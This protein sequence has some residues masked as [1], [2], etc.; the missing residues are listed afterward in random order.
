MMTKLT[1]E[2]A[3]PKLN[4][5]KTKSSA[6]SHTGLGSRSE[7]KLD[8]MGNL[9]EQ[10]K[11]LDWGL[12]ERMPSQ[13]GSEHSKERLLSGF[14]NPNDDATRLDKERG[15]QD[16][17][18]IAGWMSLGSINGVVK[19]QNDPAQ[20]KS[21]TRALTSRERARALGKSKEQNKPSF[22]PRRITQSLC[23]DSGFEDLWHR[24]A[25]HRSSG[26]SPEQYAA[27]RRDFASR[28]T[29]DSHSHGGHSHAGIRQW[30]YKAPAVVPVKNEAAVSKQ[31]AQEILAGVLYQDSLRDSRALLDGEAEGQ[32]IAGQRLGQKPHRVGAGSVR[33][34]SR[35]K[36][37]KSSEDLHDFLRIQVSPKPKSPEGK[38]N[39]NLSNVPEHG[40]RAQGEIVSYEDDVKRAQNALASQ[41]NAMILGSPETADVHVQQRRASQQGAELKFDHR[42]STNFGRVEDATGK[43]VRV[44]KAAQSHGASDHHDLELRASAFN[45]RLKR[46]LKMPSSSPGTSIL[47]DAAIK[48]RAHFMLT[49]VGETDAAELRHCDRVS[50]TLL[51]RGSWAQLEHLALN[52]EESL[53]VQKFQGMEYLFRRRPRTSSPDNT[54]S[55]KPDATLRQW[56]L[57]AEKSSR[58]GMSLSN[59]DVRSLHFLPTGVLRQL[60]AIKSQLFAPL[61]KQ[62][63]QTAFSD[64]RCALLTCKIAS[65]EYVKG[66]V[67]R[68]PANP[69]ANPANVDAT[70]LKDKHGHSCKG[71]QVAS[72]VTMDLIL[73]NGSWSKEVRLELRFSCMSCPC[74][75]DVMQLS[76]A[77]WAWIDVISS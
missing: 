29:A 63:S 77:S 17:P 58:D 74:L 43:D 30:N 51:W 71:L 68:C 34:L 4:A 59:G 25:A 60:V 13:P 15:Q 24:Q 47:S 14:S 62:R 37:D 3:R 55:D 70:A 2:Q 10:A 57:E 56:L 73:G 41:G 9:A 7:R 12:V 53:G 39:L 8:I 38:L 31:Y 18:T 42:P 75:R 36:S 11:N 72:E 69:T 49:Y 23:Q 44:D 28:V 21:F 65:L 33:A 26:A 45:S 27:G 19:L 46:P 22:S 1:H 35:G 5:G 20:V 54:Y 40:S 32:P 64:G 67:L 16:S 76:A 61:A 48:A 6:S 50:S 52:L 66:V